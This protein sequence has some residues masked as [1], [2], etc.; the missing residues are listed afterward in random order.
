MPPF[1]ALLSNVVVGHM[2]LI[3]MSVWCLGFQMKSA[4]AIDVA[5]VNAGLAIR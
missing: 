2:Q 5:V 4:T 3:G 1:A